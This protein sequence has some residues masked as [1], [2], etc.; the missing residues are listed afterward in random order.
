[1]EQSRNL[2]HL[3]EIRSAMNSNSCRW[4]NPDAADATST[5]KYEIRILHP[6][7]MISQ[8][9]LIITRKLLFFAFFNSI[10]FFKLT[11][12][13]RSKNKSHWWKKL[14]AHLLSIFIKK[15]IVNELFINLISILFIFFSFYQKLFDY[16]NF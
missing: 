13:L 1:M 8:L 10:N 16:E 9:H 11:Y 12:F 7:K 6:M 2:T 14:F 4:T 15:C 3:F 5:G